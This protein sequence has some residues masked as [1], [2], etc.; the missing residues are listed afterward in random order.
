[1]KGNKPT[2]RSELAADDARWVSLPAG[3][4]HLQGRGGATSSWPTRHGYWFA[5][6]KDLPDWHYAAHI[7]EQ[8]GRPVV[9][10]LRLYPARTLD[11][12][13]FAE[14]DAAWDEALTSL[15]RG[16]LRATTLRS[17]RLYR[18][19]ERAQQLSAHLEQIAGGQPTRPPLPTDLKQRPGRSPDPDCRYAEIAHR[20]SELCAAGERHPIATLA[21]QYVGRRGS[22]GPP[23]APH[24]FE[25]VRW[26]LK[27]ARRRGLLIPPPAPGRAGGVLTQK[28]ADVLRDALRYCRNKE[29]DHGPYPEASQGR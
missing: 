6:L 8:D 18:L 24:H 26:Q 7:V 3:T 20:Y 29:H 10:E 14:Y 23:P 22:G 25:R 11:V 4:R 21:R 9:A 15:P 12:R 17:I 2:G 16:G 28:G 27:E 1:M 13:N 19:V 5:E